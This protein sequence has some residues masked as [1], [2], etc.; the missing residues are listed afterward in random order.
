MLLRLTPEQV[1]ERWDSIK[2]GIYDALPPYSGEREELMNEILISILCERII[3]W[4]S[5]IIDDEGI[6]QVDGFVTTAIVTDPI[7]K[8]RNLL[9]YT[10]MRY[11]NEIERSWA[12]GHVALSKFGKSKNC[13]NI[14]AYTNSNAV[15]KRAK[16]AGGDISYQLIFIPLQKN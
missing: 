5:Y 4:L 9:L 13:E 6:K 14:I 2:Y 10:V 8:T 15:L 7:S 11:G 16:A 3:C 12:E 1:S